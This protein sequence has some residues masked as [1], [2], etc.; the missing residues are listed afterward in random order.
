MVNNDYI[1][2]GSANP[3]I[4]NQGNRYLSPQNPFAKEVIH[5]VDGGDQWKGWNWRYEGD[6]LLNGAFFTASG[7]RTVASYAGASSLGG[8]SSSLVGTLTSGACVLNCHKGNI[9]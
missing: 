5:R 6:L 1:H 2:C 9:C 8:K 7:V 4:N 3:T